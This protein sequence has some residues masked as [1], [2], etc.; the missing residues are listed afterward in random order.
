MTADFNSPINTTLNTS[1]WAQVRDNI[2]ALAANIFTGSNIPDATW[3]RNPTSGLMERYRL[4]DTT[5][6]PYDFDSASS[7]AANIYD[8][9]L[10]PGLTLATGMKFSFVSHQENTGATTGTITSG[11]TSLGS[12]TY[13]KRI[14]AALYDTIQGDIPNGH[15]AQCEYDGTYPILL[16]PANPLMIDR[17]V[18]AVDLVSSAAE[19]T[20]WSATLKG[21]TTDLCRGVRTCF[22]GDIKNTSGT[23]NNLDVR[24][25]LG[26]TTVATYTRSITSGTNR[27]SFVIDWLII[28]SGVTNAQRHDIRIWTNEGTAVDNSSGT[29][30]TTVVDMRGSFTLG[31]TAEDLTADKTMLIS[32]DWN[33]SDA[34]RSFRQR[35]VYSHLM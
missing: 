19:T 2:S 14:G 10:A 16:N 31:S 24:I 32:G 6:Y 15:R 25:K 1:L 27:G 29:F 26:A 13:K 33:A 18:T 5:W 21:N 30:A 11:T 20:M 17:T 28:P 22:M 4:A 34:N 9:T 23:P 35:G 8:V 3:R 7:G 12:K